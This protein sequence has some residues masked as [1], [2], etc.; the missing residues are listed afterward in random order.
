[1]LLKPQHWHLLSVVRLLE[2]LDLPLERHR[3]IL[4]LQLLLLPLH[5]QLHLGLEAGS[6]LRHVAAE[7]R[8]PENVE[9]ADV[10]VKNSS[11]TSSPTVGQ[12]IGRHGNQDLGLFVKHSITCRVSRFMYCYAECRGAKRLSLASFFRASLI[13]KGEY[14][15]NYIQICP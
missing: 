15:Q 6:H 7:D 8:L 11:F 12:N 10:N 5:L 2:P 1:V 9:G 13:F 4:V 14:L 3:P